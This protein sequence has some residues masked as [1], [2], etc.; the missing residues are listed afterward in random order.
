MNIAIFCIKK[1][2]NKSKITKPVDAYL[3][4][5]NYFHP[6]GKDLPLTF[7]VIKAQIFIKSPKLSVTPST[8]RKKIFLRF[9]YTYISATTKFSITLLRIVFFPSH[10]PAIYL[11]LECLCANRRKISVQIAYKNGVGRNSRDF[12]SSFI[13]WNTPRRSIWEFNFAKRNSFSWTTTTTPA[14]FIQVCLSESRL[15]HSILSYI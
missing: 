5:G 10:T 3:I 7:T 2:K 8:E 9:Y 15:T 6:R 12:Y 14:V 1:R 11:I 13:W 4:S